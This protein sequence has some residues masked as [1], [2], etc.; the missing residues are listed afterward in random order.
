MSGI[1]LQ[2]FADAVAVAVD[3]S[4]GT[5]DGVGC[6]V[7]IGDVGRGL[8]DVGRCLTAGVDCVGAGRHVFVVGCIRQTLDGPLIVASAPRHKDESA[9]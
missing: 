6:V 3:G 2:L 8:G 7:R 9:N 5:D 4:A 1:R